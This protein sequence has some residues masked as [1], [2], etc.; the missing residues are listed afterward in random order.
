MGQRAPDRSL[1]IMANKH[2]LHF[3]VEEDRA[4]PPPSLTPDQVEA[5]LLAVPV[6]PECQETFFVLFFSW[7]VT[8]P[9]K[10][11]QTHT[12]FFPSIDTGK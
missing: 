3:S 5:R 4:A 9:A 6:K 1:P 11:S 10:Y 2:P 12:D 8:P 7:F